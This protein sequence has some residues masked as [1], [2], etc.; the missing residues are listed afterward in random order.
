M[1]DNEVIATLRLIGFT[2]DPV[3]VSP[4]YYTRDTA[5]VVLDIDLDRITVM[6]TVTGKQ[7][8]TVTSN[9]TT[10]ALKSMLRD[11]RSIFKEVV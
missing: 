2:N 1:T 6:D 7:I 8:K 4:K 11:A 5:T 9:L 3:A 10:K